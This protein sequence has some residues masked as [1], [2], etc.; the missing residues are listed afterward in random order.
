MDTPKSA[1]PVERWSIS[2]FCLTAEIIPRPMPTTAEIIMQRKA[3][4]AVV[5]KRSMS[6]SMTGRLV[7]YEVPRSNSVTIPFT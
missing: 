3:S 7:W 1:R 6:S 2:V 4:V 5:G